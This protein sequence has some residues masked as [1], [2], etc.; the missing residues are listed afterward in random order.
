MSGI[1]GVSV[2]VCC[3]N[4]ATRIRDSL[5]HL[6]LQKVPGSILWEVVVVDNSSTDGTDEAA[7][8]FWNNCGAA[9]PLQIVEENRPGLFYARRTGIGAAKYEY[10]I[11]C[12]DDNWLCD[13]Y[14]ETA[15]KIMNTHKQV[16]A[17]GGKIEAVTTVGLPGWWEEYKHG[18]AVGSQA[19][20][21]GDCTDYNFLWGA[22]LV[23]RKSL[24]NII[25]ND[26]FPS[27]F[28]DRK[29][30]EL[31]S[32]GDSE[33]CARL[34]LMGYRLW[35]DEGLCLKHFITAERLSVSYRENL[36]K[37]HELT[38]MAMAKYYRIINEH[39]LRGWL[40]IKRT[41][42]LALKLL[43]PFGK[44]DNE[45]IKTALNAMWKLN[46]PVKDEDTKAILQFLKYR[47]QP[48]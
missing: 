43:I 19:P 7:K 4:S 33:I 46:L 41:A 22:G 40:K 12:D 8:E 47:N 34:I 5:M 1:A 10:I 42:K 20:A 28:T 35:Y 6:A 13:T 30:K 37:G 11:F 31:S 17:A 27:L 45:S 48:A 32:G 23:V 16:G 29:G 14:V 24:M 18:Y 25:V 38:R 44:N 2:V 39:K 3:Y 26:R 36:F 21:T 9:T 15:N